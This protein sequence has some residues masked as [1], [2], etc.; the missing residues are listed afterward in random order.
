MTQRSHS[1]MGNPYYAKT[2]LLMM[3]AKRYDVFNW[4][5]VQK[6]DKFSDLESLID[7]QP[8]IIITSGGMGSGLFELLTTTICKQ[9]MV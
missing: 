5:R 7:R 6:V 9:E 1:I 4:G 3:L 8:K 2:V